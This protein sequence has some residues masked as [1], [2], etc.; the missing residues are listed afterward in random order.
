MFTAIEQI[1]LS[2]EKK[3]RTLDMILKIMERMSSGEGPV[4]R[5][6]IESLPDEMRFSLKTTG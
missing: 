2:Q 3:P 5:E 4:V 6:D 1:K